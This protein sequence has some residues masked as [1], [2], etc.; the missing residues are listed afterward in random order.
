MI[1]LLLLIY[2]VKL[3]HAAIVFA[4]SKESHRQSFY[5]V[6]GK[7]NVLKKILNIVKGLTQLKVN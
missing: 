7:R 5:P 4:N 2:Y 6:W 1:F 3:Q